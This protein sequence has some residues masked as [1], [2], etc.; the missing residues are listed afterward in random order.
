M[1]KISISDVNHLAELSNLT[2][3]EDEA[4]E[5]CKDIQNILNYIDSLNSLQTEDI[6][7]TYQVTDLKNVFREDIVVDYGISKSQLLD[8][9]PKTDGESVL[10][11]KVL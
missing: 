4:K 7:P 3:S 9:A 8:L 6:E 2:I 5:L 1:N 11:P 10:V